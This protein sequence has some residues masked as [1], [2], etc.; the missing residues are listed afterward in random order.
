MNMIRSKGLLAE[1]IK[2]RPDLLTDKTGSQQRGF[3]A[4]L[5]QQGGV[6]RIVNALNLYL[7]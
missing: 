1:V 4:L 3:E 5:E 6:Y 7:R 2:I